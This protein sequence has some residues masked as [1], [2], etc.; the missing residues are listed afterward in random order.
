MNYAPKLLC[1]VVLGAT[2]GA[3]T[4]TGCARHEQAEDLGAAMGNASPERSEQSVS[5]AG[6]VLEYAAV[7]DM[8]ATAQVV[9]LRTEDTLRFYEE[10]RL[11]DATNAGDLKGA[12]LA[13]DT[14]IA[15]C[16]DLTAFAGSFVLACGDTLRIY[17]AEDAAA[18]EV[19]S[20]QQPAT[21]A[22]LLSSGELVTGSVDSNEVQLISQW[23]PG[24]AEYEAEAIAMERPTDQLVAASLDG[25]PDR[26][27]RINREYTIIQDVQW[28]DEAAGGIL[29]MGK[30]VGQ[31]AAGP[32]GMVLAADSIGNQAALYAS[33]EVIRLHQ[34][35][36]VPAGPWDVAWDSAQDWVWVSATGASE[37][38][39][40]S[41][42]TGTFVEQRT[43]P[44]V[45]DAQNVVVT[46]AGVVLAASATGAGL[47]VLAADAR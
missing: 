13:E 24:A 35:A 18:P 44:A 10:D 9:A 11:V 17:D 36:P 33:D 34:T 25:E 1:T 2:I 27:V 7:T 29:R 21:T 38:A 20:L 23:E 19:L 28:W 30:G 45:A 22:V 42:E 14:D 15:G 41:V 37:L 32:E 8:E 4:L 39:A 31:I 3:L 43:A 16:V 46:D 47:Q 40:Y 6:T 26:V 12:L 5:P